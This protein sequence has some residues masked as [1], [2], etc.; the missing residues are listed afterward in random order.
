[1]HPFMISKLFINFINSPHT[2]THPIPHSI[3]KS[4]H[5]PIFPVSDRSD[6]RRSCFTTEFF[7]GCVEALQLSDEIET[8]KHYIK[9]LNGGQAPMIK[10]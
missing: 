1:M 7:K 3:R 4:A 6:H 5:R 2:H 9:Q 10:L 8:F